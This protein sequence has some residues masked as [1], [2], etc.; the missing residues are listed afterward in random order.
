VWALGDYP[1]IAREVLAGLGWGHDWLRR[2]R[3]GPGY[4][5]WTSPRAAASPRSRRPRPEPRW[6]SPT[7]QQ[8][9]PVDRFA[10]AREYCAYYRANFGPIIATFAGVADDAAQLAALER[11]FLDYAAR[12][13]L[14]GHAERAR[15]E[16]EYLLVRARVGQE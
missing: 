13:N 1:E 8:S 14:A 2:P 11:D 7:S 4:G 6:S 15:Y 9:L 16:H 5:C 12:F 10:D 3:W